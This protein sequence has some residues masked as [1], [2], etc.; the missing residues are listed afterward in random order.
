MYDSDLVFLYLFA[1]SDVPDLV[2]DSDSADSSED[3]E[4]EV[5]QKSKTAKRG[6]KKV[7]TFLSNT[8]HHHLFSVIFTRH[9]F[10]DL[11]I[12]HYAMGWF[13]FNLFAFN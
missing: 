7:R 13:G 3:S 10:P 11:N 1:S 2:S 5:K 6:A 4:P 12:V 8:Y 9:A